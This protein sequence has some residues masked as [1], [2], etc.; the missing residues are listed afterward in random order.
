MDYYLKYIKYKNKYLE[1][2]GGA[3]PN[4]ENIELK[5]KYFPLIYSTHT[6]TFN[7]KVIKDG[8]GEIYNLTPTFKYEKNNN[9]KPNII[10]TSD[11]EKNYNIFFED[12]IVINEEN[13]IPFVLL[14][15]DNN[16]NINN[17]LQKL[18]ISKYASSNV[19]SKEQILNIQNTF[20]YY[21]NINNK[22][23][24]LNKYIF[25]NKFKELLEI[26]YSDYKNDDIKSSINNIYNNNN[27][28]NAFINISD[29]MKIYSLYKNKKNIKT[30]DISNITNID[31]KDK[32][33]NYINDEIK[34]ILELKEFINNFDKIDNIDGLK[35]FLGIKTSLIFFAN[36]IGN[37]YNNNKNNKLFPINADNLICNLLNL[38]DDKLQDKY[39]RDYKNEYI[40]F[41]TTENLN[42]ILLEAD[43]TNDVNYIIETNKKVQNLLNYKYKNI[44]YLLSEKYS[45]H[46][47]MS[48]DILN[49]YVDTG[50]NLPFYLKDIMFKLNIHKT[51]INE[52][53]QY[54]I[55]DNVDKINLYL[56]Y[57]KLIDLNN[58]GY[59]IEITDNLL[60]MI[61]K[62]NY[63]MFPKELLI[64]DT[65]GNIKN[66][67]KKYL[68]L[69]LFDYICCDFVNVD[70]LNIYIPKN[71]YLYF[72]NV[73]IIIHDLLEHYNNYEQI[74]NGS[75]NYIY[76]Y[77]KNKIT[78]E[79]INIDILYLLNK[80]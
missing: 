13:K 25:I 70:L 32:Y 58:V 53:K 80:N 8:D 60:L 35:D 18:L 1:L 66:R 3:I 21:S 38:S 64:K 37:H 27:N 23:N 10:N 62:K 79:Y 42:K 20:N 5:K 50:N 71:N 73:C 55:D 59:S 68:R 78:D 61:G 2:K 24:I 57:L 22:F 15:L 47:N 75:R 34:L 63:S 11:Y 43:L 9:V 14:L 67:N 28:N 31:G 54:C 51:F 29:M 36:F 65:N 4:I 19:L 41:P 46:L 52:I 44:I 56:S 74:L 6:I 16:F 33:N 39:K 17:K 40:N 48:I 45:I 49:K 26:I 72:K 12:E 30:K 7:N 76:D 77:K 69:T